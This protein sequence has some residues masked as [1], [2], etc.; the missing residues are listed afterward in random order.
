MNSIIKR[1][2]SSALPNLCEDTEQT[3]DHPFEPSSQT[4]ADA[5]S[6]QATAPVARDKE[7]QSRHR[8][9]AASRTDSKGMVV[10]KL[11]PEPLLSM[12]A[13]EMPDP[14]NAMLR[15]CAL[16]MHRFRPEVSIEQASNVTGGVWGTSPCQILAYALCLASL[17]HLHSNSLG[18][19]PGVVAVFKG[20]VFHEIIRRL[21]AIDAPLSDEST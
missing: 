19:A 14:G 21:P 13:I 7:R 20:K 15:L 17:G 2:S 8:D 18:H 1:E 5:H 12:W 10:R 9:A 16:Q 6:K 3:D 11:T 4:S